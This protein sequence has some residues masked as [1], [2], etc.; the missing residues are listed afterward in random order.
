[1]KTTIG[2]GEVLSVND[3]NPLATF[4]RVRFPFGVGNVRSCSIIE[5]LTST[6]APMTDSATQPPQVENDFNVLF[7]TKNTY[8]FMRLYIVLVTVLSKAK[9]ALGHS[10]CNEFFE[11]SKTKLFSPDFGAQCRSLVTSAEV[12][13]I[14]HMPLL[15]E[16][17]FSAL[18][19]LAK[20]DLFV[21]LSDLSQ[22]GLNV[23][24]LRWI[25]TIIF[26]AISY[27][28]VYALSTGS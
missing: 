10:K 2:D 18:S 14:V 4:Y 22:L 17:F 19:K 8:I 9:V 20:E 15:V 24:V 28:T 12:P 21:Q 1:V 13:Y 25:V 23:S 26:K 27:L 3:S 7:G 6:D 11:L 16:R 5:L